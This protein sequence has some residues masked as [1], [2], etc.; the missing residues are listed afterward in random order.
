MLQNKPHRFAL[1]RKENKMAK[2]SKT[3]IES[4]VGN[5]LPLRLISE[6]NIEMADIRWSVSGEGVSLRIFD[7]DAE[8]PFR[9]G[10]LLRFD[11][12]GC[13]T[14]T[15]EL[16]G[17]RYSCDVSVREMRRASSED[18]LNYYRG[19]L[20]THT[21]PIHKHDL[22]VSRTEGFQSD[23]VSFIKE[24][25]LLDFGVMTDHADVS[26]QYEYFR[27]YATAEDYEPM[28]TV[29]F[30]GCESDNI[31]M[32]TDMV[33]REY[34]AAG[35]VVVINSD[36]NKTAHGWEDLLEA[37]SKA[38]CPIGIF[39]HPVQAAWQF[40]FWLHGKNPELVDFMRC[41]EMGDG[42][43]TSC[44][45]LHEFALSSALDAGFRVTS[46]CGS[47]AHAHWGYKICPGKTV[48]MAKERSKEAFTDALR[49]NRAYASES[50]NVK[51]KLRVN[52]KCAPCDLAP[53]DKYSFSLGLS[54]FA[55]DES[56]KIVKCQ[57]ISDYGNVVY[58]KT[59]ME[60]DTLDF[61]VES[62]TARYFYL[63]LMDKEG[64]RTFSPPVW[65]GRDFDKYVEPKICRIDSSDFEAFDEVSGKDA[66]ALLD[67]DV[68]APF[69]TGEKTASIVIDMKKEE[70]ISTIAYVSPNH[71]PKL[72]EDPWS[73]TRFYAKF[74]RR[75]R[76]STSLDG[77]NYEM[78]CEGGIRTYGHE[79]MITFEEVR[80][81]YVKLEVLSTVGIE[82][83]R[84]A[85]LDA[86]L[87]LGGLLLFKNA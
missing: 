33:G 44:R 5:V 20:H 77:E 69:E 47:D 35:E 3:K 38:P 71:P 9:D 67:F 18:E 72:K 60:G 1:C 81:R 41:V 76:V 2:L 8:H 55:E 62:S 48:V 85:Y 53:V 57:V 64:R 23:M 45:M 46:S 63:R 84:A 74:P 80:A 16:D 79:E 40:E 29:L 24:E 6:E 39:A 21:T 19:D 17:V 75:Y 70:D 50:G 78:R 43:D 52:G 61:E 54:Y 26:S 14:V 4:Y 11:K 27:C 37:N 42:T 13:A 34:R 73:R 66:R 10:V 49:N 51:I 22:F 58:E 30:P 65:C 56:T 7:D 25:A 12:V 32:K 68:N 83:G 82:Y 15:A 87:H 59:S 28:R 86:T 31:I 36:Y